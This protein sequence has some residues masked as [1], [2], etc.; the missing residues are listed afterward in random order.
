M[1]ALRRPLLFTATSLLRT[2]LFIGVPLTGLVIY[3]GQADYL[4]STLAGAQTYQSF[5]PA[6]TQSLG[7]ASKGDQSIPFNDPGVKQIIANGLPADVLEKSTN[8]VIDGMY[9][10]LEGK[11][12]TPVFRVD[13]TKN[14]NY[15]AD[16]ISFYA[17]NQLTKQP[18]CMINPSQV[19]PFTAK[20]LPSNFS[21]DQE[22]QSFRDTLDQ[23]FPKTVFTANDLPK[24]SAAGSFASTYSKLPEIFKWL[25]IAPL[26]LGILGIG[27]CAAVV[28]LCRTTRLGFRLLGSV[29]LSTGMAL[30]ITPL[31]YLLAYPR[32]NSLLHLQS[33]NTGLNALSSSVIGSL[34][35]AFYLYLIKTSLI[36]VNLGLIIVL[37]ERFTRT[38]DYEFVIKRAGL[39][40]S[41]HGKQS[42]T[43][44]AN[45]YAS[46]PIQSSDGA[47]NQKQ[48]KLSERIRKLID[49]ELS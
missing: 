38:K 14:R 4:K 43:S 24:G 10:W 21:L 35:S 1:K 37:V 26:L 48:G 41:S 46:L 34:S 5:V 32:L 6:L 11:T 42:D 40:S 49:K 27:L 18:L 29:T 30:L 13:L 19:N 31:L 9:N 16:N 23:V 2:T 7:S 3:F 36:I 12:L 15:I 44:K 25:K 17:F 20:C 22:R 28:R 47:V 39:V 8:T 33:A 45:V